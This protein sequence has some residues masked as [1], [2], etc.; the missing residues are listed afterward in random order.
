[1]TNSHQAPPPPASPQWTPRQEEILDRARELVEERGLAN[2]TLKQVAERIGFSEAAIYRH[3][4]SK[5]AL[6]FALVDQLRG[7][8][9][10]PIAAIAQDRTR[11]P[12]ERLERMV[13]HHVALLRGTRGLPFL[14]LAEGIASGDQE[15]LAR[16]TGV[17]SGY[18]GILAG[19]LAEVGVP[20]TPPLA[21]QALLFIGLPAVLGLQARAFPDQA[22]AAAEVEA[23]LAHY[24]RALT[25][26]AV[27]QQEVVP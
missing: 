22:L 13:G 18:L 19:V 8:L 5:Q 11:P 25:A 7:M 10:E 1:M 12:H 3:F 4:A 24:V 16:M 6:V 20:P 15:L 9:L 26:G 14:L 27:A 2:L 23:L 17:L 21:H